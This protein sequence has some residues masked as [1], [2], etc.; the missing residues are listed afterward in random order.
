MIFRKKGSIVAAI[1]TAAVLFMGASCDPDPE[2]KVIE[3]EVETETGEIDYADYTSSNGSLHIKN[4][5]SKNMVC[6]YGQPSAGHLIGGVKANATTWLKKDSSIFTETTDFMLYVV[7][8]DDYKKYYSSS[9]T[10]LDASPYTM[11]YAFYNTNSTNE[12]VYNISNV[13]GG[14][15]A[16]KM[17]NGTDFNVELR[18]NSISGETIGYIGKQTFNKTFHVSNGDYLLFPVFKKYDSNIGEIVS[19]YPKYK[20]GSLQGKAKSFSFSLDS[21]TTNV[22]FNAQNW[23]SDINFTPSAAYIKIIN[24][25]SDSG[26]QFYTGANASAYVNSLGSKNINTGKSLTFAITMDK[27]TDNTYEDSITTSQYRVG[28]ERTTDTTCAYLSGDSSTQFTYKA[29]YL[30]TFTITGNQSDGYK[31]EVKTKTVDG[32]KV[33][34]EQ[35]IDWSN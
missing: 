16:I 26:V 24:S 4:N 14:S 2:N 19:T 34:D 33:V 21:E 23:V 28:T 6:F 30:Y 35:E 20:T 22:E 5:A 17:Q 9:P 1:I 8:E 12:Q 29:G 3:Q 18:N 10:T 15:Y 7:T 25:A 11:M 13:M 32:E 31:A 27:L